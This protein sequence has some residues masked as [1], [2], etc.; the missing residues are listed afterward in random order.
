MAEPP[1]LCN[2]AATAGV[3]SLASSASARVLAAPAGGGHH[4]CVTDLAEGR[5]R[6]QLSFG[7]L[8]PLQVESGAGPLTLGGRKQRALLG[9]LLLHA[10][11]V[12]SSDRLVDELWGERPPATAATSLRNVVTQLRKLLGTDT[13]IT[14]APGYLLQVEPERFDRARFERLLAQAR[15]AEP[16]EQ[17]RLLREALALWRG[18]P[19]A[20]LVYER[21]AQAEIRRLEELRLEALEQHFDARLALGEGPA[22]VPE[23]E[24][25]VH[26]HPLRER[27]RGQLML[28][29]YRAGRQ[30]DALAAYHDARGSLVEELGLEPGRELQDL[31]KAILRHDGKLD[32]ASPLERGRR[33]ARASKPKLAEYRRDLTQLA[34]EGKL[35]PVVGRRP[36]I[37]QTIEILSRRMTNNPVLLGPPGVGKTAI[38]EAIAQR[39]ADDEAPKIVARRNI[40]TLG[41]EAMVATTT[42]DAERILIAIEET[43]RTTP[44]SIAVIDPLHAVAPATLER[45]LGRGDTQVVGVDTDEQYRRAV[46][47][48]PGLERRFAPVHVREPTIDETIEILQGL[49]SRYEAF[50]GV[51]IS[52]DSILAA[53]RLSGRWS[54]E[55]RRPA[56]AIDLID[57]ASAGVVLRAGATVIAAD[58]AAAARAPAPTASG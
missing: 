39:V 41:L 21:F 13:I 10:G 47:A 26:V 48:D 35:D 46:A 57:R 28:A 36:E 22:L 34:R 38:V 55:R 52:D 16:R 20:D 33:P 40:V 9:L 31:E 51:R 1:P 54:R 25:L 29:L 12:V 8:G 49:R 53:A 37:E 44:S 58:V 4:C 23:L 6:Q 42:R 5:P 17:S 24:A 11:E 18:P 30:A 56:T 19:L 45:I 32:V 27:L 7:I 2:E 3:R 43:Q 50:H 14:R 15:Q